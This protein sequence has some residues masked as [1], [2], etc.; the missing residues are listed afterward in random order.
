MVGVPGRSK[1]CNS[2]RRRKKGCDLGRPR[3]ARC[4]QAGIECDGYERERIFI[5]TNPN[6]TTTVTKSKATLLPTAT[7]AEGGSD[8]SP[9]SSLPLEVAVSASLTRSAH[10]VNIIATLWNLR[11]TAEHTC[12]LATVL[13]IAKIQDKPIFLQSPCLQKSILAVCLASIGKQ[14]QTEWMVKEGLQLYGSAVKTLSKALGRLPPSTPP[15]D[16][17]LVTTRVLAMHEIISG[18]A[19]QGDP[20]MQV[21]HWPMHKMGELALLTARSPD[22]FVESPSHEMFVDARF[23]CTIAAVTVRRA[24]VLSRSDWKTIPWSKAAKSSRDFLVDILVDI[25]GLLEQL[26]VIASCADPCL[27]NTLAAK[28]LEHAHDCERMLTA[29]LDTSCPEGWGWATCPYA[30]YEDATQDDIRHANIMCLFWAV[31]A[32]VLT[33]IQSISTSPVP[34]DSHSR[35]ETIRLCCQSISRTIPLFFVLDVK[36]VGCYQIVSFP[37]FFALDGLIYTEDEMTEDTLR[38]FNLFLNP[39]KGGGSLAQFM[40]AMLKNSPVWQQSEAAKT[41]AMLAQ[42]APTL[43]KNSFL[44]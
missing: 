39:S 16:S 42:K 25:P 29:W 19:I 36:L 22:S 10:R 17:M 14:R 18:C 13:W 30:D 5:H 41:L 8:E 6:S 33:I 9:S 4:L 7:V 2:C 35:K 15:P 40:T 24:T 26:D 1:G 11:C 12:E 21:S 27:R 20:H 34:E 37:M 43:S 31:Y 28:C 23:M 44:S 38:L 32:Q 3:C